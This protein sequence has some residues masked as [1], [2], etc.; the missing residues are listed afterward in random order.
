MKQY[1]LALLPFFFL[2]AC[3]TQSPD[4]VVKGTVKNLGDGEIYFIRS[5]DEKKIDTVKVIKDQ[6]EYQT[7]VSEPTVF[8]VNFGPDQQPGFLI[9]ESG[10][11]TL[12]YEM[13]NMN[14]LNIKGGKEQDVY[15]Q[16]L[17]MCRP[18]FT[19][20]DSLGKVA[21]A[22]EDNTDLLQNLQGEFYRLDGILK[23]YQMTFIEQHKGSYATAFI[24]INYFNEKM[25][26]NQAEVEKVYNLLEEKIKGSYYGK[27]LA[28]LSTQL[29]GTSE[30][31]P[32]P[33][34]T[35]NDVSGK[36]VS[37]SSFK[38]KITLIDFWASWCGPCRAENPHV[39]AAYEQYHDKGFDIL[40]VSLDED[41]AQWEKA[42]QKD[43]LVWTQ[44][45]DLK[46]WSSS[47]AALYGVQ[48]IP[49]NF[50]LDKDGK[51]IAKD[52]RGDALEAKLKTL[53]P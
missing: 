6:F 2:I 22:N 44:V 48:S 5:G 26:K 15:N 8:M 32:A 17:T 33:D 9:L 24:A 43:G 45:S 13:G 3:K 18:V 1:L 39:V 36:P 30:G 16:F 47:A 19:Q 29:K 52:L 51:I 53:F 4:P 49:S 20:M 46:G 50:L 23:G 27:K 21:M 10:E 42:I 12:Q 38:G 31:Q 35:L 7:K 11:T 40:G 25:D 37:L 34:F 14:S 28:E 41:K